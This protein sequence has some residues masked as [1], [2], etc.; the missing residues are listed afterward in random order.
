[1]VFREEHLVARVDGGRFELQD[2]YDHPAG[3]RSTFF[4]HVR[5]LTV[6]ANCIYWEPKYPRLVTCEQLGALFAEPDRP[7][8]RVIGDI[9][10]D[11]DGSIECT[12]RATEP[13]DPVYV[14][15]PKSGEVRSGVAGDGP[16]ILAVDFL[17]CELPVDASTHFGQSLRPLIPGLARADFGGPLDKSGLP[18]ELRRATIVYQGS[19]TE[20]YRYLESE[21]H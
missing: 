8:L 17:P 2:Y 16:V 18:P 1:V 12:V 7:R 10:C 9:T 6:L 20:P 13:D 14:F 21:I 19:L 4:P 3:Y 11:V 15:E 5:H